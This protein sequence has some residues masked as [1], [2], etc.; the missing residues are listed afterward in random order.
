[1]YAKKRN[2]SRETLGENHENLRENAKALSGSENIQDRWV[3]GRTWARNVAVW[4]ARK[5]AD[6]MSPASSARTAV[7]PSCGRIYTRQNRIYTRQHRIYTP[8]LPSLSAAP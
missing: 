4:S 8:L 2:V 5:V 1:M 6:L 7:S 3:S